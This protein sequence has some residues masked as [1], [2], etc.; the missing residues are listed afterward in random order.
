M[1]VST[2]VTKSKESRIV[3]RALF[4][5]NF[6]TPPRHQR[7]LRTS[8]ISFSLGWTQT[9]LDLNFKRSY[10]MDANQNGDTKKKTYHKKATGQALE[11]AEKHS[12]DNELK[13]F[14]SCFW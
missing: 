7:L 2:T 6:T 12:G 9:P 14:G 4:Q 13:L 10:S 3:L 11:T 1:L 8:S 5:T